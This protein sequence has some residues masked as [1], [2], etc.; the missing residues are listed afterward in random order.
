MSL[1]VTAPL[2]AKDTADSD[3]LAQWIAGAVPCF[4]GNVPVRYTEALRALFRRNHV[5]EKVVREAF[6]KLKLKGMTF[7]GTGPT[8]VDVGEL[9]PPKER[10]WRTDSPARMQEHSDGDKVQ[11]MKHTFQELEARYTLAIRTNNAAAA[12]SVVGAVLSLLWGLAKGYGKTKQAQQN[13]K[14]VEWEELNAAVDEAL[15]RARTLQSHVRTL[16]REEFRRLSDAPTPDEFRRV[17]SQ[18]ATRITNRTIPPARRS[19][20]K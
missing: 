19:R 13:V 3:R 16:T 12:E 6:A 18:V 15:E 9:A 4:P 20:R 10:P 1:L 11:S 14:K 5:P 17:T 7:E 8:P 2:A